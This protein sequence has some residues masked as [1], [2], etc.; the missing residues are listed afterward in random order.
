V[1]LANGDAGGGGPNLPDFVRA[2]P[3]A[4]WTHT[5]GPIAPDKVAGKVVAVIGAGSNAF[6][7]AGVALEAGAAEVH[8][9]N[10]RPYIDYQ[11]QLPTAA[12]RPPAPPVDR[13]YVNSLEMGYELPDVVRWRNFL[14]GER[15]V[16]SVPLDS[17]QRA[18]A[19]NNFH[20]HLSTSLADVGLAANGKIVAKAGRES[21]RFVHMIAA[22]GYRIDLAE[23]PELARVHEQVALWRDRYQPEKG[24]ESSAGAL[25]PY[26][27]SGFEFLPRA[28]T[29]A[30]YLRNIHCFNLAAALSFGVPVGDVPSMILHPRLVTAIE[31]DFTVAGVDIATNQRFIEAPLTPPDPAPYERAVTGSARNAA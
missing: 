16:A 25:H 23:Q 29:G 4:V 24:E 27:G 6:D 20:I 19:F 28:G 12:P 7:A 14:L 18:V 22:T 9:F 11:G 10:R 1:V 3:A 26:L 13:G 17:M 21:L 30:E 8:L 31:R 2:L 15:R 5:T